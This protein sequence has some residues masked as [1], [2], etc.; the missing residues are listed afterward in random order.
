MRADLER[1]RSLAR[2]LEEEEWL[3]AKAH[4]LAAIAELEAHRA[5]NVGANE[6]RG[7]LA[8]ENCAGQRHTDSG[9]TLCPACE[10]TGEQPMHR[11][12]MG[13][14]AD[15]ARSLNGH[16]VSTEKLSELVR[17]CVSITKPA[18]NVG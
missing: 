17:L 12:F 14:L 10:G 16:P 9:T 6:G 2:D 3:M 5:Q 7:E 11:K 13:P 1:L 8:C 4:V 15:W 18:Q